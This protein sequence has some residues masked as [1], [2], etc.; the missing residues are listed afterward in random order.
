MYAY[1]PSIRQSGS[2]YI[3]QTND[4]S[5]HHSA[6]SLSI[7]QSD[8]KPY[9]QLI[10]RSFSEEVSQTIGQSVGQ[11]VDETIN[12]SIATLHGKTYTNDHLLNVRKL[13]DSSRI[14]NGFEVVLTPCNNVLTLGPDL[15]TV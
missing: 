12:P 11:S 2:H 6:A 8:S 3:N 14:A 13:T 9:N 1:I 5:V 4:H 10:S 7:S 15:L